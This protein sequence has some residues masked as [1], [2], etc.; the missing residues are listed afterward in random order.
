MS[1]ELLIRVLGL[2]GAYRTDD[3]SYCELFESDIVDAL[4][5]DIAAYMEKPLPEQK[6]IGYTSQSNISDLKSGESMPIYCSNEPTGSLD[7]PIYSDIP[8][9]K[10]LPDPVPGVAMRDGQPALVKIGTEDQY[11]GRL[12]AEQPA[13]H[14]KGQWSISDDGYQISSDDSTHEV[15]LAIDGYFADIYQRKAYANGLA[16]RLNAEPQARKPF[17]FNELINK[18]CGELPEGYQIIIECENGYGVVNLLLPDTDAEIDGHSDDS[19]VEDMA[20]ALLE[21]AKNHGI[22]EQQ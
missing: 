4:V 16:Q 2:M 6:P 3:T 18:I 10:P 11:E 5:E 13:I 14:D 8:E 20:L 19:T 12:Y 1:R 7:K 17:T 15:I 9:S 21:Q 22:K